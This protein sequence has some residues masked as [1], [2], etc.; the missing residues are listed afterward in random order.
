M[1]K[2]LCQQLADP[3][4]EAQ[5]ER[6]QNHEENAKPVDQ[7]GLTGLSCHNSPSQVMI[8]V[9]AAIPPAALPGLRGNDHRDSPR[10]TNRYS[11]PLAGSGAINT[12][13]VM[14]RQVS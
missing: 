6:V 1:G 8:V 11:A 5:P 9:L 14:Q 13:S 7:N 4:P 12:R 2:G 3:K 10:T